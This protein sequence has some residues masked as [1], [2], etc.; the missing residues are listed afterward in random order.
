MSTRLPSPPRIIGIVVKHVP[1]FPGYA[2]SSDGRMFSCKHR[3]KTY[4]KWKIRKQSASQGYRVIRLR[5]GKRRIMKH[6]HRLVLLAFRGPCPRGMECCH[7]NGVRDDNRIDNL[8]WDT[9]SNNLADQIN[10]GNSMRGEKNHHAKL[11]ADKVRKILM[12]FRSGMGTTELAKS[13]GMHRSTMLRIV[14][15]TYWR[16]LTSPRGGDRRE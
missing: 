9:H 6:V 4:H 10:H 11:T 12:R 13:F 15:G 5:I 8:R 2:V 16:H 3:T 7:K 14:N 1:G